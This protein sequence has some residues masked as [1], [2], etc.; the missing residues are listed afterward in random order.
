MLIGELKPNVAIRGLIFPEPVQIPVWK[1]RTPL[2]RRRPGQKEMIGV[3]TAVR[4]GWNRG[5]S[6]EKIMS[7][8][9]LIIFSGAQGQLG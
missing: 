8:T 2:D 5:C 6:Q 4:Q 3:L 1:R 9:I 7:S